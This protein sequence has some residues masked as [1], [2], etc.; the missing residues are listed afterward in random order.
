[1]T[2]YGTNSGIGFALLEHPRR[3]ERQPETR[4]LN[5]ADIGMGVGTLAA[6]GRPGD[7]IRFYEINPDVIHLAR[8]Y[9]TYVR[10]ATAEVEVVLGDGRLS[11]ERECALKSQP[12]YDVLTVDAFSGDAVPVH[13]LTRECFKIYADRLAEDGILAFH[14]SSR[15]LD[16]TPL[17]GTL[18]AELGMRTFWK[19]TPAANPEGTRR[20]FWVLATKN[21]AFLAKLKSAPGFTEFAGDTR[22]SVVWTDDHINL[23]TIF[24]RETPTSRPRRRARAKASSVALNAR[25][26]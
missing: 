21:V 20:A 12:K 4:A 15:F 24:R 10:D 3:Y 5:I 8:K 14:V 16:L 22:R 7:R 18:C 19:D 1:L 25:R 2:Y 11:L 13:L 23:F 9:F 6:Y 17:V 26:K